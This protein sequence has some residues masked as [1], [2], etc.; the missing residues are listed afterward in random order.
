MHTLISLCLFVVLLDFLSG[1]WDIPL[2]EHFPGKLF[3]EAVSGFR[4]F[5]LFLN[6]K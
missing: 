5:C 6:V 2:E 1:I 3:L 4:S